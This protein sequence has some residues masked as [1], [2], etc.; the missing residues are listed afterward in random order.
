MRILLSIILGLWTLSGLAAS[1]DDVVYVCHGQRA[2]RLQLRH[3]GE[4]VFL[5]DTLRLGF[6]ECYPLSAVDSI[7]TTEPS[8]LHVEDLG[9]QGDL[10][11]GASWY[12][13][14]SGGLG[15]TVFNNSPF[16]FWSTDGKCQQAMRVWAMI[17]PPDVADKLLNDP[18][19]NTPGPVVTYGGK[20][21]YVKR[22]LT[23]RRKRSLEDAPLS[24]PVY[25]DFRASYDVRDSIFKMEDIYTKLL[26]GKPMADVQRIV[27]CWVHPWAD[28]EALPSTVQFGTYS[29]GHYH[30][31]IANAYLTQNPVA[32]T[33]DLKFSDDGTRVV[34]DEMRLRYYNQISLRNETLAD[35]ATLQA[36]QGV[37]VWLD[38][39]TIVIS[40]Q[41]DLS[42]DEAL[43]SL[44]RIDLDLVFPELYET[45]P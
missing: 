16:W 10:H 42:L 36:E 45:T 25:G 2:D 37:S 17:L 13:Y 30:I 29:D 44:I 33:I 39:D 22:T 18:S 11:E 15:L 26:A 1:T 24:P 34:G 9:W 8:T 21:R 14:Y 23:R 43:R 35:F 40:E 41:C 5:P 6:N 7:V 32:I 19:I 31:E 4:G 38:A 27:Y 3:L 12:Y 20:Y 28:D